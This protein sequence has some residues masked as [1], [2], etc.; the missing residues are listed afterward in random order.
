M[1]GDTY[2]P[3]IGGAEVHIYELRKRLIAAGDRVDLMV[4]V[5]AEAEEDDQYPTYRFGWSLFKA[6][7]LL[8]KMF[9][10]SKKADLY[11]S[12]N[13]YK[14][15]MLLGFVAFVRRKPFIITLHG[16]GLLDNPNTPW[17]YSLLHRFYRRASLFWATKI[18]STSEDLA[19]FCYKYV[20]KK[21]II[22]IPNGLDT[23]YFDSDSVLP[24]TDTR[25]NDTYPL[26]LTVRRL[27]PKNGI[28]Y[29]ISALPWILKKYPNAKLAL[30]GD[31]RMRTALEAR[32]KK[33][34]VYESCIFLGSLKNSQV[35]QIAVRADVVLFPSTAESTSIACGEM[36]SLKKN[37][38]SSRVGG[39]IELIGK[40]QERGWLVSLVP[41][42]SC[43]YD[44]PLELPEEK[45]ILLANAIINALESPES[46]NKRQMAR[47]FAVD[48]LDWDVIAKRTSEIYKSL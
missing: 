40:N 12:H 4:T 46:Q 35:P 24:T 45:Y 15:A 42:E 20:P 23:K 5:P 48:N 30:I 31:G 43:N 34:G 6:P 21:R 22:V 27:V 39:L 29:A 44:A 1:T 16:L 47:I 10:L 26:L 9:K 3:L 13:P 33:L 2:F 19:Q 28:H 8:Y 11:H 32:A 18:I 38:V 36:L 17:Y 14:L 7:W 37:V 25:F 41:W